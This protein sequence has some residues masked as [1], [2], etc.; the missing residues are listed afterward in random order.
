MDKFLGI[1]LGSTRIKS[2]LV[3]EDFKPVATGA[4]EWENKFENGFWT[5]G[6]DEMWEGVRASVASLEL[7]DVRGVGVSAMMHGYLAF[8]KAGELL[9]PFRTWR[10]TTTE[11]A[12]TEL[13]KRFDFNVPQRWSIAHLYQAILNGETHVCD[14][15]YMTTLAGYVHWKL[16]G[17]KVLG[18]GDASGMF[19]L[20]N[21]GYNMRMAD[22]FYKE[23]GVRV[24]EVF[25]RILNAGDDAGRL[26][27]EGAKLL[28]LPSRLAGTPL[29][30]PEG[31][32]GTGMVATNA[33]APRTG[34]IS[35]GTSVFA[36]IVLEN[37]LKNVYTEIDMVTT[38]TGKPV[39]MVHCNNCTS[40]L[41]AWVRV[42][43]E[44]LSCFGVDVSKSE[45]YE[46]LYS[47]AVSDGADSDCG[48]LLAYNFFSGEPIVGLDE[49]RPLFVRSL[50]ADFTLSNFMRTLLFSSMAT[51]RIG[52]E[53]L[54]EE[55][56][57]LEKIQGHGGLFK[58][59]GVAQRLMAAALGTP[60]D[61]METAGEGGAWGMA[62]LAAYKN[63][64]GGI[65]LDKFLSERVFANAGGDNLS[66]AEKSD[67]DGF[68]KFLKNYRRGLAVQKS[69]VENV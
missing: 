13:T 49:G 39:A 66:K 30:P 18:V 37:D 21:G 34:N 46:K 11:K 52:M 12:A 58:T 51:L 29:C 65:T 38:P 36:M 63:A 26:T 45:L 60:V 6:L 68:E 62:L 54:W 41:D 20:E 14:I 8:D 59:P 15:D 27:E 42:F 28:G 24:T 17:E 31:D 25:P 55:N 9:T 69:A 50:G 5:Y 3:G 47:M 33:I 1:E 35:A 19:P 44:S 32:A 53:I 48:G 57:S 67:M 64:G 4:F 61:V 2:V 16:T 40:D 7:S 10:N 43:G 23:T 22:D 56:V